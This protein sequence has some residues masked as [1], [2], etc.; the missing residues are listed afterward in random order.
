VTSPIQTSPAGSR[1]RAF[2]P[3]S[4]QFPVAEVEEARR[5][6]VGLQAATSS[7]QVDPHA[8]TRSPKIGEL[9]VQLELFKDRE[10]VG[11]ECLDS[12]EPVI[13][14]LRGGSKRQVL[15]V[16]MPY[17]C[18]NLRSRFRAS[19]A[20]RNNSTFS[21]DIAN[22]VSR[23]QSGRQESRRAGRSDVARAPGEAGSVKGSLLPGVSALLSVHVPSCLLLRDCNWSWS[24]AWWG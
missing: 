1:A 19:A 20:S 10:G 6:D 14:A 13:R 24:A 21:R 12:R 3:K 8:S 9:V 17:V 11:Y 7:S 5:F 18:A 4:S 2:E 23:A 22:S 15:H 16:R